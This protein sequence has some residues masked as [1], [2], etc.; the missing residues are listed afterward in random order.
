MQF[1]GTLECITTQEEADEAARSLC[2]EQSEDDPDGDAEEGS[3]QGEPSDA[4]TSGET[5]QKAT[6]KAGDVYYKDV[7]IKIM[8]S[9]WKIQV[10]QWLGWDQDHKKACQHQARV[11]A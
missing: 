2:R 9:E 3:Q 6:P 8:R 10:P 4:G 5:P 11:L 1:R 7:A